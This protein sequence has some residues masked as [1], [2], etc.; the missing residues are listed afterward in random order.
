[1]LLRKKSEAFAIFP[2]IINF[3]G[4]NF[5]RNG[6]MNSTKFEANF[7]NN[8]CAFRSPAKAY[9][10]IS[11]TPDTFLFENCVFQV[12]TNHLVEK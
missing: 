12:F 10:A 3:S 11:F 4:L 2:P 8:E 6:V 5:W 9:K 7:L 1:M